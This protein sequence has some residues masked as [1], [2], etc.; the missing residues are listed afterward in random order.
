MKRVF[1]PNDETETLFRSAVFIGLTPEAALHLEPC[2][3]PL[4]FLEDFGLGSHAIEQVQGKQT[5][6]RV[7]RCPSLDCARLPDSPRFFIHN[8]LPF[9]A[10][11]TQ[12]VLVVMHIY[13][14]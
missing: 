6:L 11:I 8:L 4:R 12:M 10:S 5:C 3:L 13:A 7:S 1:S 2:P 14:K 9:L